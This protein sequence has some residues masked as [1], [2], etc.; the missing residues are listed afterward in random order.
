MPDSNNTTR[1]DDHLVWRVIKQEKLFQKAVFALYTRHCVDAHGVKAD[2]NVLDSLS[3]VHTIAPCTDERGR[4]CFVMIRQFRHGSRSIVLEFP[5]GVVSQGEE[6]LHAGARELTEESGYSAEN[7]TVIGITNP[8]PAMMTNNVYTLLAHNVF[9]K[10]H[11]QP[12]DTERL[13][14]E[15]VPQEDVLNLRRPDFNTHAL[16]IVALQWYQKY[17][18]N[19][20]S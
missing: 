6:P 19:Q 20:H 8:N 3:W 1:N 10:G 4:E 11:P 16:M 14:T 18:R 7:F 15:L 13:E 17:R 12:D 2:F 5:G 9:R